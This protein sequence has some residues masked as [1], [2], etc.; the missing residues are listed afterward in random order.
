MVLDL[1]VRCG[2]EFASPY[3]ETSKPGA[4]ILRFGQETGLSASLLD[5][6]KLM[7]VL[8]RPIN[9]IWEVKSRP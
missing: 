5:T 2:S 9:T 3:F 4:N 6:R 8:R 7:H 1:H